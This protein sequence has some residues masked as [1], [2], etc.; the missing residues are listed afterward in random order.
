MKTPK[1][2]PL[3]L[4]I[5]ILLVNFAC[6]GFDDKYQVTPINPISDQFKLYAA[7]D[8]NSYWVYQNEANTSVDTIRVRSVLR[9]TR[10]HFDNTTTEGY[11]YEAMEIGFESGTTGIIRTELIAGFQAPTVD[12][13]NESLR[14]H[15]RNGRYFRIFMPKY[16]VGET[17]LLGINEGNYTNLGQFGTYELNG[18]SYTDV[19]HT[20][21][22]DYHSG[23]DTVRLTFFLAR[24]FGLIEY[25]IDQPDGSS[26]HWTLL[27]ADI[28]MVKDN[29]R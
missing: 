13:M 11:R 26:E 1:I 24:N 14:I 3:S 10:V 21:V 5:T 2:V 23:A 19:F 16:P 7:F 20:E 15:F 22:K 4:I 6:S 9:D 12:Q 8:T 29:D 28:R 27:E 17:Q 18:S 25:K